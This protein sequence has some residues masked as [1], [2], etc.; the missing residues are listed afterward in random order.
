MRR[1]P[2]CHF[3]ETSRGRL[4]GVLHGASGHHVKVGVVFVPAF[5]EEMNK[6]RR[7]VALAARRLA[8]AG[9]VVLVLDLSGTGDSSGDFGDASWV[10]W[11]EDVRAAATWLADRVAVPV[12]LWGH[13]AGCLLACEAAAA[14][15]APMRLLFWQPPPSGK[16]LLQ[17]FLRLKAMADLSD[18]RVKGQMSAIKAQLASGE[19]VD[20]AGY[21]LSPALAAGL[22]AAQLRPPPGAALGLFFEVSGSTGDELSP[23]MGLAMSAWADAGV[24][25]KAQVVQGPQFWQTTEIEE[26]PELL[27]VTE[28]QFRRAIE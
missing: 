24:P 27:K 9:A 6:S 8:D 22:D 16:P 3:I 13:R 25:I 14:M 5:A 10:G 11:V 1:G 26:V 2:Q 12:W 17:Q 4:F 7:M 19:S 18:G 21:R 28:Q 20:V 15:T 23:A